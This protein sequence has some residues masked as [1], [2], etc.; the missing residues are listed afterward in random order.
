MLL[1][2]KTIFNFRKVLAKVLFLFF[3][4]FFATACSSGNDYE[5][6][7]TIT[8]T[9]IDYETGDPLPN[10]SILLSPGSITKVT[11]SNGHF[12]FESLDAQQYNLTAQK[13]GYQPNRKNVNAI[14]G[15]TIDIQIP[16]TKIPQ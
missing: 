1:Y 5:I 10:V 11:D 3:I 13:A 15:E 4:T 14:S 9:V 6:F 12:T 2:M 16:M 7:S 8:G